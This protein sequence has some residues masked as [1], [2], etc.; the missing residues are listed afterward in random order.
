MMKSDEEL[1]KEATAKRERKWLD[2]LI[3]RLQDQKFYG[4]L[5]ITL[6]NGNIQRTTKTESMI[7]PTR[8]P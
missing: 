5:E 3:D 6:E 2:L 8:G 7:P 4:K 1:H